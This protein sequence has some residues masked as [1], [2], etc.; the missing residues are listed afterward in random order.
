MPKN[1][2]A[3][4][5]SKSRGK[6]QVA[7]AIT[8]ADDDGQVYGL[9]ERA[10]G[11]KFFEV[12]CTD[13]KKRRSKAR[14]KWPRV[15]AGDWCI[16]SLRDFDDSTGDIIHVYKPEEVKTLM[17]KGILPSDTGNGDYPDIGFSFEDVSDN[18]EQELDFDDI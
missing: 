7:R 18:E 11:N 5:N 6:G 17:K 4:K 14:K 8:Y 16:I 2:K 3:K 12:V 15:N 1:T 13:G 9:A 10:L